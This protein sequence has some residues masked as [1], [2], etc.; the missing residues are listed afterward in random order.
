MKK[1][2][3]GMVRNRLRQTVTQ[4][5]GGEGV[6]R[7]SKSGEMTWKRK[8][9]EVTQYQTNIKPCLVAATRKGLYQTK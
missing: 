6:Q 8:L 4:K 2:V 3:I 9:V 1:K 5:E 7:L